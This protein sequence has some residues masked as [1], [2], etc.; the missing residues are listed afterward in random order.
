MVA[1]WGNSKKPRLDIE[2]EPE[3]KQRLQ[4]DALRKDKTVK[5][6]ITELIIR[7]LRRS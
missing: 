5:A 1:T 4:M 6:I 2:I 7:Y 3:L